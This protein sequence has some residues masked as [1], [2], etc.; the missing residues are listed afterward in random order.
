MGQYSS[1]IIV[2]L[3]FLLIIFWYSQTKFKNKMLCTFLRPNKQKIE[4]WVPLYSKHIIFDR[5]KYGIERYRVKPEC[6]VLTWY[7]RGVNR[8]FPTLIPTLDYR[9]DDAN[10]I[11]PS[12]KDKQVK[13]DPQVEAAAYQGQSY[14]GLTRAMNQQAGIKRNKIQE[15][16]PLIILGVVIIIG[17]VTY[18]GLAGLQQQ[19]S[20]VQQIQN[21]KK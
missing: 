10:P 20:A 15:L 18:T 9:W 11:D 13:P 5:N 14:V 1:S 7:A 8:L 6:V 16:I 21:L 12:T 2:I 3:F 4:K 19:I 17:F